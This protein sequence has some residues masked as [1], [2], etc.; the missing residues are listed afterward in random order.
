MNRSRLRQSALKIVRFCLVGIANTSVYYLLYLLLL[1][2]LPYL[3]AH[4]IAYSFGVVF[5]FFANCVIT[6]RVRPTLRRFLEFPIT[7]LGNF[8]ITSLGAWV[9]VEAGWLVPRWATLVS[10]V[11]AIPFTFLV[12][13]YVLTRSTNE[14]PAST[15]DSEYSNA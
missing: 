10:T 5:S 15:Q 4:V 7:T 11:V 13:S 3:G 12:T 6:F 9:L 14:D 1:R 2:F 8:L